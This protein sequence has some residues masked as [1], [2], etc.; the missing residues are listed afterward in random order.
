LDAGV[1]IQLLSFFCCPFADFE[2]FALQREF[3]FFTIAVRPITQRLKP[4]S[5]DLLVE[6][7][8]APLAKFM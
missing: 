4:N 7:G 8:S 3:G 1:S 5:V 6:T 2:V